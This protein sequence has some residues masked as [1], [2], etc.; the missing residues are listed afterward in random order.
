MVK[1]LSTFLRTPQHVSSMKYKDYIKILENF[2]FSQ[3]SEFTN[4]FINESMK[5]S[6]FNYWWRD[7]LVVF[8]NKATLSK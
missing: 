6:K 2:N 3:N 5:E 4:T 8:E 7:S 1:F